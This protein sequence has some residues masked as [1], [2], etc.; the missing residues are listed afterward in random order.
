[1]RKNLF[2]ITVVIIMSLL[3]IYLSGCA[4]VARGE[5]LPG[6]E[7]NAPSINTGYFRGKILVPNPQVYGR[8]YTVPENEEAKKFVAKTGRKDLVSK[9]PG[10]TIWTEDNDMPDNYMPLHGATVTMG[11]KQMLTDIDGNFSFTDMNVGIFPVVVEHSLYTTTREWMPVYSSSDS[12]LQAEGATAFMITNKIGSADTDELFATPQEKILLRAI[13]MIDGVPEKA[14]AI[15]WTVTGTSGTISNRGVFTAKEPGTSIIQAES[16]G[17]RGRIKI[18]VV[19]GTGAIYGYTMKDWA[20]PYYEWDGT[21]VDNVI[22]SAGKLSCVTTDG[23]YY[24]INGVPSGE[25]AIYAEY[26][27]DPYLCGQE[28]H[29]RVEQEK[30]QNCPLS[31][32]QHSR[33]TDTI[34][35]IVRKVPFGSIPDSTA[36]VPA[37]TALSSTN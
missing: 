17:L 25:W 18:T 26:M 28:K 21:P 15:T 10:M 30:E 35:S 13:K 3:S 2:C 8:S 6:I 9:I 37:C 4:G 34:T 29:F 24:Y 1:M 20:K 22:V 7:I 19:S 5:A 31:L 14:P 32:I 12:I 16:G 11:D 23:G 33:P 27:E 36:Y